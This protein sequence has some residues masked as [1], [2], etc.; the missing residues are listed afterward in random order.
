[1]KRSGTKR[2]ERRK[3]QGLWSKEFLKRVKPE[4]EAGLVLMYKFEKLIGRESM[5]GSNEG[6]QREK[7]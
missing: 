4:I 5:E 7:E 3:N 2:K 1:M 6:L